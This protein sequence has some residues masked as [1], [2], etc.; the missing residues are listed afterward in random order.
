MKAYVYSANGAA[1]TDVVKPAPK[2]T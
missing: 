1:I 2:G